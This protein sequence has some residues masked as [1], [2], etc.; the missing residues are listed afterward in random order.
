MIVR[1]SSH[2]H[3]S[4]YSNAAVGPDLAASGLDQSGLSE[5]ALGPDETK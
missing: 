2:M 5:E 4:F 1:Y 3:S